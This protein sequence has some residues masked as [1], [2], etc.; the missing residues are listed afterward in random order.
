M[1]Q[2]ILVSI[3]CLTYNHF[4]YIRQCLNGFIMQ[5]TTFA[6]EV[7]I[8]DDASTDGT[9]EII[10]EYEL[11]YPNIVKPIYQIENQYSKGVKVQRVYNYPR[12]KGK[13]IAFCEGDDYWSDPYKLQKQV[14]I[15]ENN[16]NA[17]FVYTNFQ[18]IEEN[19]D[20]IIRPVYEDYARNSFSGDIFGRLIRG[21]FILTLTTC[22]RKD[23][24]FCDE[25]VKAPVSLDYLWFLIASSKGPV[26]YIP[27]KTGC[28][29]LQPNGLTSLMPQKISK[30]TLEVFKYVSRLYLNKQIRKRNF[31]DDFSI[32]T[33]ILRRA[34][35]LYLD[36][37]KDLWHEIVYHHRLLLPYIVPAVIEILI[38]RIR[39]YKK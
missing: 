26:Y 22:F 9:A 2:D 16:P 7:L 31:K 33:F 8:H 28:Y 5:R 34:I 21:N 18:T 29:R 23:I 30:M 36:S 11:R 39:R 32:K 37:D 1:S 6:F 35:G 12:A 15:L 13:Y 25:L 4:P 27:D 24:L 14:D 20:Y 38:C 19:G 17:T 3:S 10:R